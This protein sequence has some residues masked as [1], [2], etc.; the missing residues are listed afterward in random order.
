MSGYVGLS[1][2]KSWKQGAIGSKEHKY[3]L[4]KASAGLAVGPVALIDDG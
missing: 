4:W 1:R 3:N 2:R